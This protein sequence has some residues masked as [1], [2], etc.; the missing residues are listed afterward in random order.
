MSASSRTTLSRSTSSQARSFVYT[1]RKRSKSCAVSGLGLS[2]RSTSRTCQPC[3]VRRVRASAPTSAVTK[4]IR[5]TFV[6]WA[7]RDFP[8][9]STPGKYPSPLHSVVMYAVFMKTRAVALRATMRRVMKLSTE[10]APEVS[11]RQARSCAPANR[12]VHAPFLRL[13]K[14][15]RHQRLPGGH[16]FQQLGAES[17]PRRSVIGRPALGFWA[18]D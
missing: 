18:Q 1:F 4:T 9:A 16:L 12:H 15:Q 2:S 17:A 6:P 7:S 5:G 11:A 3:S 10:R 13:R 14:R 8:S